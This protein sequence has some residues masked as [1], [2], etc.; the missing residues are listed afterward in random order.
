M[1]GF[2]K[3]LAGSGNGVEN[4]NKESCDSELIETNE[5]EFKPWKVISSDFTS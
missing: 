4:L 2:Y 3:E 5:V 1:D